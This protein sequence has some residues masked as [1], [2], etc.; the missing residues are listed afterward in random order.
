[1]DGGSQ[2]TIVGHKELLYNY[3]PYSKGKMKVLGFN[4][5]A[6]EGSEV[7]GSGTLLIQIGNRFLSLFTLVVP[8]APNIIAEGDIATNRD[9]L[10]TLKNNLK[11]IQLKPNI[12]KLKAVNKLYHWPNHLIIVPTDHGS[13]FPSMTSLE[14]A[15]IE[16][17][18]SN[19]LIHH[20]VGI[21]CLMIHEK[22]GHASKGKIINS[23][24]KKTIGY[25][26]EELEAY[27]SANDACVECLLGKAQRSFSDKSTFEKHH[28]NS[29][30]FSEVATDIC[31]V[32]SGR[33][34]SKTISKGFITFQCMTT[35]YTKI[36]II[37]DKSAA[38]VCA[39]IREFRNFVKTQFGYRI[40]V[41]LS[42]KGR[43][44]DN[45]RVNQVLI[46]YG[47]ILIT[48]SG[49]TP[50]T[51]GMAERL[52]LTVMNSVRTLLA[53]SLLPP[54][55]WP[56]A[57]L[58]ITVLKNHLYSERRKGSPAPLL[59]LK[60]LHSKYLIPF[61]TTVIV[62]VLPY[63]TAK[64]ETRGSLALNLGYDDHCRGYTLFIPKSDLE[65][66]DVNKLGNQDYGF[67][68]YSRHVKVLVPHINYID[69]MKQK[70][71]NAQMI[72]PSL[73]DLT[74]DM[75]EEP[76]S[77][78]FDA[79][80]V[81]SKTEGEH[82]QFN[83]LEELDQK[84]D[85][86]EVD[87]ISV[88]DP[89]PIERHDEPT[90]D[91]LHSQAKEESMTVQPT[92]TVPSDGINL[93]SQNLPSS[94][95]RQ[96][97]DDMPT[98][99]D[100]TKRIRIKYIRVNEMSLSKYISVSGYPRVL[101]THIGIN[102]ENTIPKS[103]HEVIRHPEKTQW[104]DAM[105]AELSRHK[106]LESWESQWIHTNDEETIR[107]ALPTKWIY[108]KK[109]NN[110]FKARLTMRGDLQTPDSYETTYAAPI[111]IEALKAMLSVAT[112][113][114]WYFTQTDISTA[115]LY[116]KLDT[117]ILIKPPSG[118]NIPKF[119]KKG[120]R[121]LLKLKK[122]IYGLKQSAHLWAEELGSTLR[123]LGFESKYAFPGVYTKRNES[124]K[125]VGM[126]ATFVDDIIVM[127]SRNKTQQQTL[128][129]WQ[130]KYKVKIMDKDTITGR[131]KFVGAE[132]VVKTNDNGQLREISIN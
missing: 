124:G 38:T 15:N 97:E 73:I 129:L 17:S 52:N 87:N 49:Y 26:E 44:D 128:K 113:K 50:S 36:F 84:H 30:P 28:Q 4:E 88:S 56:E 82:E 98:Q 106:E 47:I 3:K 85:S 24:K 43:E 95:K 90:D 1:M 35:G 119:D 66:F 77:K 13:Y 127:C 10:I 5:H 62:T 86:S 63:P 29:D 21:R 111:R 2:A 91:N 12:I 108:T 25:D 107:S 48:T 64:T 46:E 11:T 109:S 89:N 121:I 70:I 69:Y 45:E 75:D 94:K 19:H 80:L 9:V 34:T 18:V 23:V 59:G 6:S 130:E 96:R 117:N 22:L 61:G 103:F 37:D 105:S 93:L 76:E 53:T 31:M 42:D 104:Q 32:N 27:R 115:Y 132:M 92:Q 126:V 131:L 114:G 120:L 54:R 110:H 67:Y 7:T 16:H 41:I 78:L 71:R 116:A 81:Q 99:E 83:D 33:Q 102:E 74:T 58:Y 100:Q 123:E 39:K 8:N 40:K 51:N 72:H 79:E 112:E 57:A 65:T 122:T 14:Q 55:L 118:T 60:P 68:E 101:N 20:P 125:V